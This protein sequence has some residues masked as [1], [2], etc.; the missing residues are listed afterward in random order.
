[1]SRYSC[2]ICDCPYFRGMPGGPIDMCL[3]QHNKFSQHDWVSWGGMEYYGRFGAIAYSI[4]T[5]AF[6]WSFRQEDQIMADRIALTGCVG[7]DAR[8][9][10][11]GVNV[12]LAL[13]M[14]D[15]RTHAWGW[16]TKAAAEAA[17]RAMVSM[18]DYIARNGLNSTNRRIAV[19]VDTT[20]GLLEI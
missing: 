3:C 8:I 20:K 1:M 17:Q 16:S 10:V 13:A 11:G 9:V 5:G 12:F 4:T 2:K 6:G 19:L 15:D 14:A 7:S 18:E